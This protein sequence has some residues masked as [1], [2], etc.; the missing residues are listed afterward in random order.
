VLLNTSSCPAPNYWP[1]STANAT[2]LAHALRQAAEQ[3]AAARKAGLAEQQLLSAAEARRL[4]QERQA[5]VTA[6]AQAG[7]QVWVWR[8]SC[9]TLSCSLA[10][11]VAR[12]SAIPAMPHMVM[13]CYQKLTCMLPTRGPCVAACPARR[14]CSGD[15]DRSSTS[16]R[17]Q[18]ITGQAHCGMCGQLQ[19]LP[20]TQ[21][22]RQ[23]LLLLLSATNSGDAHSSDS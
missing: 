20:G 8:Q 14:H 21:S 5:A 1:D 2:A 15:I 12:V 16:A 6:A 17:R 4:E 10:G 19:L 23:Q 22:S 13:Q 11:W 18:A 3:E 7:K 9:R